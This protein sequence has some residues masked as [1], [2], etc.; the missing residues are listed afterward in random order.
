MTPLS[1]LQ[2]LCWRDPRNPSYI[3][4]AAD[5][6]PPRINC[7]CDNCFYG[8]DT[9]AVALLS[10]KASNGLLR[11]ALRDILDCASIPGPVG[12]TAYIISSERID[13]ARQAYRAT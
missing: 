11:R 5:G 3:E 7:A 6:Y 1:I 4:T 2:N 8:R 13:A 10:M 9:L 12:T